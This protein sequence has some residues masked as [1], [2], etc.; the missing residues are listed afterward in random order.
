[1]KKAVLLSI[2]LLAITSFVS[3][4]D[5]NDEETIFETTAIDPNE[6]GETDPEEE[7]TGEEDG[8]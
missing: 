5:L 7:E 8:V 1:M 4:T 2:M 3:C 6:T